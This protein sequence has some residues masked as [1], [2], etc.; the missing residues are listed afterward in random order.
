MILKKVTKKYGDL[1][2]ND[3]ISF[4]TAKGK[5]YAI[6]GHSGAGKTTLLNIMGL[7]DTPTSGSV[8][9]DNREVSELTEKEKAKMRLTN[10]GFVFQEFY[11]NEA[12]KAYENV[13]IPMIINPTLKRT[14]MKGRACEILRSLGLEPRLN[15]YPG[16]LSGGEK[17]RVAIGRA[18]ANNPQYVLAD[19]P[20]GNLDKENEKKILEILRNIAADKKTVIVVT[21]SE[22]VLE[23][24]DCVF[25]MNSGVLSDGTEI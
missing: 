15:H 5:F 24:A 14:D 7:L 12:L 6:V 23:Y 2:V 11:L 1:I 3:D 19:E 8:L 17:Q 4:E 25:V 9:I 21:H 22:R 18:L 16:E 20:T 10:I 13:M